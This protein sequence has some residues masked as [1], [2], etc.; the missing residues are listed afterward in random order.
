MPEFNVNSHQLADSWCGFPQCRESCFL[1]KNVKGG[2]E[3]A[4][5]SQ[6]HGSCEEAK[7]VFLY[8]P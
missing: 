4:F 2:D 5:V 1:E 8:Y 3:G 7:L 6:R